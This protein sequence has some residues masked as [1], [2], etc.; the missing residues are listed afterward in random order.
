MDVK[1][2]KKLPVMIVFVLILIVLGVSFLY[3]KLNADTPSDDMANLNTIYTPKE[4]TASVIANGVLS[5]ARGLYQD[6]TVYLSLGIVRNELN[7]HFYWD[8]AE[9]LLI[10]TTAQEIVQADSDS[11]FQGAPVFLELE[12]GDTPDANVY[13]SLDYVANYTNIQVDTYGAPARVFIRTCYGNCSY[14]TVEEEAAVRVAADVKS[15]ILTRVAA[16]SRL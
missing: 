7:S 1:R 6:Q 15:P 3:H 4:G 2:N 9:K 8:D 5:E 11:L 12:D 10:C 14:A 13:I 16:G